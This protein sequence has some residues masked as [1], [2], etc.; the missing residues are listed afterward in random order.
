MGDKIIIEVYKTKNPDDFTKLLADPESRLDVGSAAASTAAS[1]AALM[2]RAAAITAAAKP[3]EARVEYILRN[4]ETLRAYMIHLIDEDVKSRAPLLKALKEGDA[5][6]IEAARQPAA[7]I[8]SEIVNMMAQALELMEELSSHA[9]GEAM[10][11][12]GEGAELAMAAVR[13]CMI[14]LLAMADKCSD[15]TYRFVTRREN[16]ITREACHATYGRIMERVMPA[17]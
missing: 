5:R 15:D 7:C 14:Y 2:R 1:A 10:P 17:V 12:I 3:E 8:A 6:R 4:S 11:F 16:E 9:P 13:S